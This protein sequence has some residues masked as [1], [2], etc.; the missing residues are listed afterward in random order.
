MRRLNLYYRF[1]LPDEN[2]GLPTL[3]AGVLVASLPTVAG[4]KKKSLYHILVYGINHN[5]AG[6]LRAF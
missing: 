5:H 6:A 2:D 4:E 1:L 3:P